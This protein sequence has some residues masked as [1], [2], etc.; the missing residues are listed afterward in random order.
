MKNSGKQMSVFMG[1]HVGDS[2]SSCLNFADLSGGLIFN[3]CGLEL[4]AQG[5]Q[6]DVRNAFTKPGWVASCERWNRRRRADRVAVHQDNVAS[7]A[8]FW[9]FA[10]DPNCL[11]EGQR[12]GHERGR[13]E[14]SGAM[15]FENCT[16]DTAG[17][18]EIVRIHNEPS[19][20]G[21]V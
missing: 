16:V 21:E 15:S 20:A 14:Y 10:R 2:D 18:P 11:I 8:Q 7:D 6:G 3:L 9:G 1:V 5:T 19:H 12:V 13:C 17:E 4:M